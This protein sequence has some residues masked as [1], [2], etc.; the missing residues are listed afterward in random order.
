M[1]FSDRKSTRHLFSIL[2]LTCSVF[3]LTVHSSPVTTSQTTYGPDGND[4]FGVDQYD[5]TE[6]SSN[7]GDEVT[8]P[9]TS[10]VP[11]APQLSLSSRARLLPAQLTANDIP[12]NF[13]CG[14]RG[15]QEM[16]ATRG[17]IVG[18]IT[19]KTRWPWMVQLLRKDDNELICGATLLSDQHVITAA[20]CIRGVNKEI[21]QDQLIVRIGDHYR[22]EIELQEQDLT[23]EC[24]FIHPT[25]N[26]NTL[27]NDLAILKLKIDPLN[28]IKFTSDVLPVC[29]PEKRE[30]KNGQECFITG[31]GHT[32]FYDYLYNQASTKLQEAAV[33]LL[34]N[35]ACQRLGRIYGTDLTK[36][37][38]CAGYVSGTLR[39]DTCKKDS[40]GPLVCQNKEG[41]WKLWGVTSWGDNTFCEDSPDLPSP[42]VYTRVD[43][44]L[45]WINLKLGET[46]PK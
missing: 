6:M 18:G 33:P 36:K 1:N 14:V 31:W 43:K 10:S 22:D 19:A 37:M 44:Y 39:A 29:M 42:G 21:S 46:C 35:R 32:D 45:S 34:G 20:H 27:K 28:P 7:D 12:T 5:D 11:Q 16:D 17:R 30:F 9:L 13:Q 25:Y 2:S 38:Q 40:G 15:P 24:M 8:I 23:V 3:A 26:P 4:M 41:V